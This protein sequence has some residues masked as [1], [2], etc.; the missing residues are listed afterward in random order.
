MVG[1][2]R[3]FS[4]SGALWPATRRTSSLRRTLNA[5]FTSGCSCCATARSVCQ[6]GFSR[7]GG[8]GSCGSALTESEAGEGLRR[9]FAGHGPWHFVLWPCFFSTGAPGVLVQVRALRRQDWAQ[10]IA[11][12]PALW[13][14]LVCKP[15]CV[16]LRSDLGRP[17]TSGQSKTWMSAK[18]FQD[19]VAPGP[20]LEG[21][22][23]TDMA[24]GDRRACLA[25]SRFAGCVPPWGGGPQ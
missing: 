1:R 5:G 8:V 25:R 13:T 21:Q 6:F 3:C 23:A 12:R 15:L 18:L 20:A 16:G 24:S 19:G 11:H 2:A 14:E 4:L 9:S 10:R 22:S 17:R 7:K